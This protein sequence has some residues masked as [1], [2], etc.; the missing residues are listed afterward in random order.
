VGDGSDASFHRS[1]SMTLSFDCLFNTSHSGSSSSTTR[2][3]DCV[4]SPLISS[5]DSTAAFQ[6]FDFRLFILWRGVETCVVRDW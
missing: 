6:C 3:S 2:A 1:E 4:L 5:L